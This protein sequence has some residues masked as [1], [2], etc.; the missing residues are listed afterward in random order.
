MD[1]IF[2]NN[3]PYNDYIHYNQTENYGIKITKEDFIE[4]EKFKGLI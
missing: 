1:N 2:I 3:N 4:D